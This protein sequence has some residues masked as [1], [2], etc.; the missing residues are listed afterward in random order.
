MKYLTPFLCGIAL[1]IAL[2]LV[3][4]LTASYSPLS[5]YFMTVPDFD[6]NSLQWWWL[7]VYDNSILIITVA[8]VLWLYR[9]FFPSAPYN[10]KAMLLMQLPLALS[11]ATA[12]LHSGFFPGNVYQDV[13]TVNRIFFAVVVV[14]LYACHRI[15]RNQSAPR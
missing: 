1:L 7:A 15:I 6:G 9:H 11:S 13:I 12:L 10:V 3:F 8:L 4:T 2:I 14:L 5:S